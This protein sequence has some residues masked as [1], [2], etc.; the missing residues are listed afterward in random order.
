MEQE[1][2]SFWSEIKKFEDSLSQDP[3]SL[4]F[5]PL[6]ELY[7]VVGMLD[8]AISVAENGTA[9]HPDYLRGYLVLGRSY[10]DKGM[11]AQAREVLE[12]VVRVTP[13]NLVAQKY[14]STIYIDAG[15]NDLAR[16]SLQI[17]L[18]AN[19]ADT[20]SRILL[21][22][23][24]RI[25]GRES[26]EIVEPDQVY[27]TGSTERGYYQLELQPGEDEDD[28]EEI[29][30]LEELDESQDELE[31]LYAEC[32]SF[33]GKDEPSDFAE[34]ADTPPIVGIRTATLA[35]LYVA[36]GHQEQALEVYRDLVISE[37]GNSA[38]RIRLAELDNPTAAD[39]QDIS[40]AASLPEESVSYDESHGFMKRL[41]DFLENIRRV[42]ECRSE[43]L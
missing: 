16:Q 18:T 8:D 41:E 10:S 23:L 2:A 39:L 30:L 26:E 19:P 11:T 40:P 37:P 25:S 28:L 24:E 42:R 31:D 27:A 35:E 29:E 20:E 17:L 36:Q 6:A 9:Q 38:Y 5:A 33:E 13:D 32:C 15:E 3:A 22:S 4:S 34:C 12:R 21:E 43:I 14:L 7:R 1:K